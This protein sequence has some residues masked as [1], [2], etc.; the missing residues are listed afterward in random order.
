MTPPFERA[1]QVLRSSTIRHGFFGRLGGVSTGIYTALNAGPGSSDRPEAVTENRRRIAGALGTDPT[2][3]LTLHQ[4]HSATVRVVE[5]PFSGQRPQGDALVTTAPGLAI[6]ALSADCVPVLIAD[7]EAGV[8]AA[9]HAGWKGAV[10]GVVEATLDCMGRMGARTAWCEAVIGPAIAQHS[11]EVG[12]E[13]RNAVL[14]SY[15]DAEGFF[16]PGQGDRLMFDLPGMVS[17]TLA[18]RGLRVENLSIDTFTGDGSWFSHRRSVR[19]GEPDYG[20]NLSAI[21]IAPH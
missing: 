16:A 5:G 1:A 3:L 11:Y 17:A 19:R 13:L 7:A 2:R 15:P 21:M 10:A 9:I 20:R 6:G 14:A 12:P 8:V 4:T 18:R